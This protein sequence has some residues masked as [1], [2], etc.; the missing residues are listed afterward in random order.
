[1][2]RPV[3]RGLDYFPLD[4]DIFTDF[5]VKI[6]RGRYGS[7]GVLLYI[8]LLCEI[9]KNGYY[10]NYNSDVLYCLMAD[11]NMSEDKTRQIINFLL[12]RSLFEDTLFQSDKVLTAASIQCRYQEACKNRKR[13]IEVVEKFWVLDENETL[14]FIKM[15]PQKSKSEKNTNKS[16]N[17]SFNSGNNSTKESKAKE[18]KLNDIKVV[19]AQDDK[20]YADDEND[21]SNDE[22][23]NQLSLIGKHNVV[24]LSS[25][26][27]DKL[28]N[29]MDLEA[30]DYYLDKLGNFITNK[31]AYVKNHY[32]TILKWYNEDKKL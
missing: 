24:L 30:F 8:Y 10:L 21:D 16:E 4:V 1:M 27:I 3:K 12:E 32:Q 9:Y 5:K 15:Y 2:A 6:V 28:L 17:N 20:S 25:N 19:V 18:S 31:N 14:S 22:K 11:L 7:D 26:Q 13:D 29:V 23:E